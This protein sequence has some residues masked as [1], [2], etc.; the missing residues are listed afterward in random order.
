[1]T[2]PIDELTG[3]V[4]EVVRSTLIKRGYRL[5]PSKIVTRAIVAVTMSLVKD[6]LQ[7][8]Q[9]FRTRLFKE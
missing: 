5:L 9:E 4:Y 1:V 6:M 2:E 8:D 7:N 3:I